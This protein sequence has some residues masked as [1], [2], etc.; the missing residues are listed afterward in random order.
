MKQK[1][2]KVLFI[3]SEKSFLEQ[4][5]EELS[6]K[7]LDAHLYPFDNLDRAF[8]FIEKQIIEKNNKVHYILLNANIAGEQLYSSLEKFDELNGFLKKPDIIVLTEK[9]NHHLRNR[10]MQYPFVS[11][12]I[13]KPIPSDYIEFLITGQFA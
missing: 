1:R 10:V 8:E 2:K 7:E 5:K 6:N 3:D 9:N 11:A 13:V 12:L 4:Q